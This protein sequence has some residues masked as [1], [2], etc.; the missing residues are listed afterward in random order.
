MPDAKRRYQKDSERG[1]L[2]WVR[3][4]REIA[5]PMPMFPKKAQRIQK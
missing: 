4:V 2:K 5:H 3:Y 1:V